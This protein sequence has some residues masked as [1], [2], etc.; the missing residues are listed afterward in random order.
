MSP[1]WADLFIARFTEAQY[2]TT[3]VDDY[4]D[5][6]MSNT[7]IIMSI[8]YGQSPM[9]FVEDM[10]PLLRRRRKGEC[11]DIGLSSAT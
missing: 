1:E 3:V 7:L 10:S 6:R 2:D 9:A 8:I 5:R 4:E 11:R